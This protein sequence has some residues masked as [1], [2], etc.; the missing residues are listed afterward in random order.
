MKK[1]LPLNSYKGIGLYRGNRP[2][3]QNRTGVV[4]RDSQIHDGLIK[5]TEALCRELGVR[6]GYPPD[7]AR[8]SIEAE[9]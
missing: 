5:E 3:H 2:G 8:S 7:G 4:V 9:A 6:Y 1:A